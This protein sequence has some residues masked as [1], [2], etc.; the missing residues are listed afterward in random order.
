MQ[1]RTNH[2]CCRDGGNKSAVYKIETVTLKTSHTNK[3]LL[4]CKWEKKPPKNQF[5]K[6]KR[7]TTGFGLDFGWALLNIGYQRKKN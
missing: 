2:K 7:L 1:F 5:K 4:G 3:A 6:K